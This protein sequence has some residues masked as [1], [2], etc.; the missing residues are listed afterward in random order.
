MYIIWQIKLI[1]WTEYEIGNGE[2]WR[3]FADNYVPL[4]INEIVNGEGWR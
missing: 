1:N 3:R 4:S 2:R